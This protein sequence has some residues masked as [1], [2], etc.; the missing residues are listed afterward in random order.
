[1]LSLLLGPLLWIQIM[2]TQDLLKLQAPPADQR[3]AYGA[4]PLQFGE[5]RLPAGKGPHPVA[6]VIHGGC[7]QAAFGLDHIGSLSAA[8]AQAGV[9][10]WTIEYR[11]VG[12]PGGGWPGTFQDVGRGVDHVRELAK[13]Y[14][15]D[16]K[17]VV[18][19]GH[20]A[21]GHL[22]LW[23]AAR[24]RLPKD[25]PLA[26]TNPMPLRGAISLAGVPDL[27]QGAAQH[28][29][30]NAVE[31]LLGG[32]AT[33]VPDRYRQGSPAELLPLS[34]PQV[35]LHGALDSIVP[36]A[37][38]EAHVAA[39]RKAGDPVRLQI[40]PNAGHFELIAPKSA[41]WPAVLEAV[42]SLLR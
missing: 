33:Q 36:P 3:I 37:F 38:S 29:C 15:L 22:A 11:R 35:L 6:V 21:G 41:A 31:Q 5:L 2:T 13:K 7:W 42:Q 23:V 10:A 27:R 14:P 39:A 17:R 1:M 26:S 30:G 25:S 9:A 32:S 4:D 19:M 8:L 12:N 16:L 20:S 40:L 34:V 24:P 18:V 28:V